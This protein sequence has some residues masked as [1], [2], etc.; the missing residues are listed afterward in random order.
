[1]QTLI[2]WSTK[3]LL[4]FFLYCMKLKTCEINPLYAISYTCGIWYVFFSCLE[5]EKCCVF[6]LL[7]IYFTSIVQIVC[8]KIEVWKYVLVKQ[9]LRY[10]NSVIALLLIDTDI[11][12][13]IK[14]DHMYTTQHILIFWVH[15]IQFNLIYLN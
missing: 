15:M 10:K 8:Y 14:Y 12:N 9:I 7:Y 2:S 11:Y 13:Y 5:L 4:K 3:A 1:M 6:V